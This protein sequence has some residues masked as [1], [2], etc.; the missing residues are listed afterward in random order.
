MASAPDMLVLGGGGVL[1]EAWMGGLLAGYEDATGYKLADCEAF[2]GTSAG[3]IVAARIAAGR[4]LPRPGGKADL[5][6]TV[7]EVRFRRVPAAVDTVVAPVLN[8]AQHSLA[9]LAAA[10]AALRTPISS[11]TTPAAELALALSAPFAEAAL[12]VTTPAGALARIAAL[13][14]LPRA[15]GTLG[16]LRESLERQQLSFDGRLLV[17]AVDRA[18]GRRVIFGAPGAPEASVADAVIASCTVPWLFAPVPIGGAEYVDGGVWSPANLDAAPV[19]RGTR[20]LCLNPTAGL[21]GP[22]AVLSL[23]RNASRSVTGFEATV[24]KARGAE[25]SVIA[26]NR[27]AGLAMSPNLMAFGPQEEVLAAGYRQGLALAA[28]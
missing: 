4:A 2:L 28:A 9:P 15:S 12:G 20:V 8:V 25:V 5:L 13:K 16:A 18:T 7:P 17:A 6:P 21:R 22:S 23:A 1:G 10:A 3:S 19:K 27:E 11:L 14:A 26:P 24:L